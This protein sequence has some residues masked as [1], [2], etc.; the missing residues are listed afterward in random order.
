M[1]K[2]KLCLALE[3]MLTYTVA[4]EEGN[5]NVISLIKNHRFTRKVK[6]HQARKP[7]AAELCQGV[8]DPKLT[9]FMGTQLLQQHF[10]TPDS[11]YSLPPTP[12][13]IPQSPCCYRSTDSPTKQQAT[14]I[15]PVYSF[16]YLNLF[17]SFTWQL[18]QNECIK[19][20]GMQ[21]KDIANLAQIQPLQTCRQHHALG[22]SGEHTPASTASL[23][24]NWASACL[25]ALTVSS[26]KEKEASCQ[27][28][29]GQE[30]PKAVLLSPN[31][32]LS[33]EV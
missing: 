10:F 24:P 13:K 33:Q 16:F 32:S 28:A 12:S 19:D 17:C 9:K 20:K 21:G 22:F 14:G 4:T 26:C 15:R 7:A 30:I 27:E 23:L 31:I 29:A 11:T 1:V 3:K 8:S 18:M 6:G 25:F 2:W 5:L